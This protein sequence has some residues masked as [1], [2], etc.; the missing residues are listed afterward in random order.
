M[1]VQFDDARDLLAEAGKFQDP[2]VTRDGQERASVAFKGYDTLWFNTGTLC[3]LACQNCYIESTPKNDRLQ[4]LSLAEVEDFIEQLIED[5]SGREIGFTG[6]EPFM[7]PEFL[8]ILEAALSRGFEVLVLT[9]AMKPMWHKRDGL[10]ELQEKYGAQLTLRVSLDH[11]AQEK[12][13]MER[14]PNS[15]RPALQGL[16]WLAENGFNIHIASR[17]FWGEDDAAMR[18]GFARFFAAEKL[19]I[20][21]MDP[22]QLILFPEMDG[23]LAVPEITTACWGILDVD[24]ANMM[25]A[26]SR[27]IVHRKGD[28]QAKALACT[29]LAYDAEF[30]MGLDLKQARQSVY[31]NHPHCAK[32]CVLGGGSCSVS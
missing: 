9:N 4:Y 16:S 12:H 29:L 1:S 8:A 15:W 10:L 11:Y 23:D 7:N 6:G 13:E 18:K 2:K 14:G 5:G 32:F 20:D 26:S 25:C 3:N 21:A 24:P 28:A 22:M 27:M 30:E 17:T 19:P 31:L